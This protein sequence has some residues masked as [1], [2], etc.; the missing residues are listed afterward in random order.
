MTIAPGI[1]QRMVWCC[2]AGAVFKPRRM[3]VI[4][5]AFFHLFDINNVN[6]EN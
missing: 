2:D 6:R 3:I 4:T 5:A 1:R